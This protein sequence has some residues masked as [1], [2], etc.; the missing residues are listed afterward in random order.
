MKGRKSKKAK[1]KREDE[2]K[3]CFHQRL[4]KAALYSV[5]TFAFLLLP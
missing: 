5:L 4:I 2:E 3:R 1:G